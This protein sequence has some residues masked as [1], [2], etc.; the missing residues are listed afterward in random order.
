MLS[1]VLDLMHY[2]NMTI[3]TTIAA[4]ALVVAT[5][6]SLVQISTWKNKR[7][8]TTVALSIGD[9]ADPRSGTT[10][11]TPLLIVTVTATGESVGLTDIS[12]PWLEDKPMEPGTGYSLSR[13]DL[14]DTR[15]AIDHT[16]PNGT[17]CVMAAGE[18]R[19]WTFVMTPLDAPRRLRAD[20][21][22]ASGKVVSSP[23]ISWR[24]FEDEELSF[25]RS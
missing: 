4:L 15:T 24:P 6:N 17:R 23:T 14:F 16:D 25:G 12:F 1:C 21:T 9:S 18:Q 22:L 19:T 11:H 2:S 8:R 7:Q 10:V 20:V 3:T 5:V 13:W